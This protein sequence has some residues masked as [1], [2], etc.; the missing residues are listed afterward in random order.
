MGVVD[1][2]VGRL[3]RAER[4]KHLTFLWCWSPPRLVQCVVPR[5]VATDFR[6]GAFVRV[7]GRWQHYRGRRP[8]CH[9][10]E[11]AADAVTILSSPAH[12]A[13][14]Q[15]L[16]GL[17]RSTALYARNVAVANGQAHLDGAGFIRLPTPLIVGSETT[18]GT[19]SPF[20]VIHSTRHAFL[21][22]SNLVSAHEAVAAG[23]DSV[24]LMS[25][26]FWQHHSS[27][28]SS[29]AEINLVEFARAGAGVAGMRS[30]TEAVIES[31]RT[32]LWGE[33][34]VLLP[35]NNL[36]LPIK[37][38]PVMTYAEVAELVRRAGI[39]LRGRHAI[40]RTANEVVCRE[41]GT[42][43]YWATDPPSDATPYYAREIDGRSVA[44]ELHLAGVG[45]VASGSEWVTDPSGARAVTSEF[46]RTAAGDRYLAA[47]ERGL[48]TGTAGM[49]LG[50]DRLLMHL[51]GVRRA[52]DVV[53][54]P[55][56]SRSLRMAPPTANS[57]SV[58]VEPERS[59][60]SA[61]A[62]RGSSARLVALT[63][64]LLD[65]GFSRCVTSLLAE[66]WHGVL[67]KDV[68]EVDYF[69]R[70]VTLVASREPI[71]HHLLAECPVPVFEM[72]PTARG[73]PRWTEPRRT[74]D[75]AV[76]DPEPY[77]LYSLVDELL[78]L[79]TDGRDCPT[80][81]PLRPG[82]PG[83]LRGSVDGVNLEGTEW[84]WR[85]RPIARAGLWINAE[86]EVD[87]ALGQVGPTVDLDPLRR[88]L[89]SG[90]PP[91]GGA[92]IDLRPTSDRRKK[93]IP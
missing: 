22:V 40:P 47:I 93:L 18:Y 62:V 26:L 16:A 41:L 25:S 6:V 66:R 27:D 81:A 20:R 13:A 17:A 31:V 76:I 68:P 7:T 58:G 82:R 80:R 45:E 44:V 84:A 85:G 11:M 46:A 60:P 9:H 42:T 23:L 19:T 71:H 75:I 14:G 77:A 48:P 12:Q 49:S 63:R 89:R 24:Q 8:E 73:G 91:S 56:N 88:F 34:R 33:V 61:T 30:A 69:G 51:L 43:G 57:P 15:G 35:A 90:P 52:S 10:R 67:G 78:A 54:T 70:R 36:D 64:W 5:T 32:A 3:V 28:R 55:R 4:H 21:T 74:L 72:G 79:V 39:D 38:L 1:G 92:S 37:D 87:G 86:S 59:A 2:C 50:I 65:R 53:P 83:Y 29:L